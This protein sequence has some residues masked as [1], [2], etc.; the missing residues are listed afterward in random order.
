MTLSN[1]NR[2]RQYCSNTQYVWNGM[3][4]SVFVFNSVPAH[5]AHAMS[6]QWIRA[7]WRHYLGA[8]FH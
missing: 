7:I 3:I 4:N 5:Q 6:Y 1:D 2:Y 8:I